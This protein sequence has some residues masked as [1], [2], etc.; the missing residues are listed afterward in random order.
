MKQDSKEPADPRDGDQ[1]A[2]GCL[3]VC[4]SQ[5]SYHDA[6]LRLSYSAGAFLSKVLLGLQ[7]RYLKSIS[8]RCDA[9]GNLA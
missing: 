3:G 2:R 7:F 1:P 4:G 9:I 6:P 5:R 8:T